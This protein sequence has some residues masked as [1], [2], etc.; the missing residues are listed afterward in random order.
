MDGQSEIAN[1]TIIDLLEAHVMEVNQCDQWERYLP[2]VEY[3]Y[4]DTIHTSMG[5]T[6]FEIVEGRPK[7]PLVV[8]CLNNVCLQRMSIA[9]I[10][11]N[12]FKGLKMLSQ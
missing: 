10:L 7:L 6:P 5:K 1:L 12:L 9:K 3:A 11:Q 4:N 8:K 2:M